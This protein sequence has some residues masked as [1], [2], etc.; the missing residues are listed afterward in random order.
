[1][2]GLG[3][4][5]EAVWNLSH[6]TVAS[7]INYGHIKRISEEKLPENQ[8]NYTSPPYSHGVTGKRYM[9]KTN[10]YKN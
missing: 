8:L 7:I 1:M 5:S 10:S 6:K 3:L 2:L 4:G 9:K